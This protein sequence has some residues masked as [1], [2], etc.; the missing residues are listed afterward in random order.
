MHSKTFNSHEAGEEEKDKG[1]EFQTSTSHAR[2]AVLFYDF[3]LFISYV[4][5]YSTHCSLISGHT[6]P[7]K[8]ET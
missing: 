2:Y 6:S 5:F 1:L 4:C 8:I 3:L 7:N